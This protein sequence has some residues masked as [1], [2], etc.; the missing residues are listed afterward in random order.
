MVRIKIEDIGESRRTP[1]GDCEILDY[2]FVQHRSGRYFTQYLLKDLLNELVEDMRRNVQRDYDNVILI[3]G[4]EGSGKSAAMYWLLRTYKGESWDDARDIPA[5]YTYN[6]EFMRERLMN[7]DLSSKMF[8]M[9]ETT[10]IANNRDWQSTDNKDFVSMLETFRSKKCLFGGCAPKLERVDVYLRDFRMR[11]HIHL[12]PMTFK[13]TGYLPRGIFELEK[14]NPQSG[15]MEHVG[16]GLYPD[17]PDEAKEIYLP[18]KEK[19]QDDLRQKI[20][21]GGKGNRYKGMYE[22]EKKKNNEIMLQLHDLHYVEDSELMRLFGY[23]NR[24][25][26]ANALSTTRQRIRDRDGDKVED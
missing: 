13:S 17:M 5:C 12:Q 8:W 24:G 1:I 16:Y 4:G 19:C 11:Y 18:L 2:N 23:D 9:D 10:Q 7:N 25:T 26:F 6:M 15:E 21:T 3:T 14:R 20:S 22:N